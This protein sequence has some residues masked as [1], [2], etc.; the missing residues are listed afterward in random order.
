MSGGAGL[1]DVCLTVRMHVFALQF[2]YVF[3]GLAVLLIARAPST[4][5]CG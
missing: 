4:H 1:F 2:L 5:A 3:A